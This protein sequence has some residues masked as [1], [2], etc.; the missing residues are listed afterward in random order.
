MA[1][2]EPRSV[3][4]IVVRHIECTCRTV[5]DGRHA[6][7][8]LAE[9]TQRFELGEAE[10]QVLWC[11]RSAANEGLDQTT[12]ARKLAISPAQ[13]SAIVERA[14]ARDWIDQQSA[15]SDRRRRLWQLSAS[16]R[17]LL[18]QMIGAAALLRREPIVESASGSGEV[19]A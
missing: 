8:V 3:S 13:V 11:L 1:A 14:G 6:A 12:L 19:A 17:S 4:E 9:W 18:E 15:A 16:G 5:V 2:A 10:F 7:R